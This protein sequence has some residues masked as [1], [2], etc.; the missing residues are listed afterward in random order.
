MSN[1]PPLLAEPFTARP[2]DRLL[3]AVG[4]VSEHDHVVTVRASGDLDCSTAPTLVSALSDASRLHGVHSSWAARPTV[5][6]NLS[7]VTFLDLAGITALTDGR[8]ELKAMGCGL[9]LV[10]PQS[11]VLRLLDFAVFC[12]WL[13]PD[14]ECASGHPWPEVVRPMRPPLGRGYHRPGAVADARPSA[15]RL[16]ASR[17]VGVGKTTVRVDR[18]GDARTP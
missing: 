6:L 16:P 8:A 14:L 4:S 1:D 15:G 5:Q 3:L 18:A 12:G 17:L 13:P 9:C 10:S 11:N 2:S 7:A